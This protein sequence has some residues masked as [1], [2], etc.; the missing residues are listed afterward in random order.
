MRWRRCKVGGYIRKTTASKMYKNDSQKSEKDVR[1]RRK[2]K[3][4]NV[5]KNIQ[6]YDLCIKSFLNI[7]KR[8][9]IFER[10]IQK[11]IDKFELHAPTVFVKAGE[12][13]VPCLYSNFFY[14]DIFMNVRC[15]N[16]LYKD[17]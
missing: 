15:K 12:K 8:N 14:I 7:V 5:G 17:L 11:C 4:R 10:N 1:S 2:E 16:K 3:D 9:D 13:F 6:N